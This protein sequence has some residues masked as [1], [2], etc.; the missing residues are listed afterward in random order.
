MHSRR[1]VEPAASANGMCLTLF[2]G[3]TQCVSR[4]G[5][6]CAGVENALLKL[7]AESQVRPKGNMS[8]TQEPHF[9]WNV[10]GIRFE[11]TCNAS[12]I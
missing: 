4:C 3:I 12:N 11:V 2:S 9:N 6:I 7:T 5:H 8:S 10:Y 1:S